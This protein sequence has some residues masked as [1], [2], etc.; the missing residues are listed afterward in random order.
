MIRIGIGARDSFG[1]SRVY[2]NVGFTSDLKDEVKNRDNWTC[3]ACG[4]KHRLE[5]H[6]IAK[7]RHGG[8]NDI[9]NLITLCA[10][11]H[12][13]IDTLDLD[14]ALRICKKNA[15]KYLG[16][17]KKVVDYKTTKEKVEDI[18]VDLRAI[19]NILRKSLD[20]PDIQDS[21][22]KFNEVLE[23]IESISGF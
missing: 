4:N 21:I 8:T 7:L 15:E 1:I 12:R 3:R 5:V 9:D 18:G 19:Y 20:D 2:N 22:V 13:A 16:I 11:C 17:E 14:H 6:H 23:T 10:S